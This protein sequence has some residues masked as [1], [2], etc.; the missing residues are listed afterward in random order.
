MYYFNLRRY[1]YYLSK[2]LSLLLKTFYVY[3]CD[4]VLQN[5]VRHLRINQGIYKEKVKCHE[6]IITKIS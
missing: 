4:Y 2:K 3:V 5:I 1:T 6:P